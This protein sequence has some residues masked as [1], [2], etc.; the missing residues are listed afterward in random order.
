VDDA[1]VGRALRALRARRRWRQADLAAAAGVSQTVVSRAERGHL[2]ALALRTVRALFSAVDAGCNLSPWWRSGELDRLIDEDHAALVALAVAY[3]ER[4]GWT[5]SV[6]VT[7]AVYGDRGSIDILAT[8]SADRAV[9]VVEVKSRLLSVE[10]LL[11]T[12]D[13]KVRLA[14]RI[15]EE[16]E[17]WRPR[18]VGRLV[19]FAD[20]STNR[21][22][23]SRSVVLGT[24]LTLR[25]DAVGAWL[26]N[27][28]GGT[29]GLIFLSLSPAG[30]TR[31]VSVSP[32]RVRRLSACTAGSQVGPRI[33]PRCV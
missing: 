21:R 27:P 7:F 11:R 23:V 25:G 15:V 2:D 1:Q 30:T 13:R 18:I 29:S 24:A 20:D 32:K 26:R 14:S 31:R 3:L 28:L 4:R 16:R 19:V 9:L 17:G 5:V 22:R 33:R 12:L 10:E 8:R 6:E